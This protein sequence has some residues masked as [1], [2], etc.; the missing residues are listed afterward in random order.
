MK[1]VELAKKDVLL[2]LRDRKALM[3]LIAMPLILNAILGFALGGMFRGSEPALGGA[4]KI[5]VANEDQ[6]EL[7]RF[8]TDIFSSAEIRKLVTPQAATREE[9]IAAVDGGKASAAVIVPEGF[10]TAVGKGE[11]ASIEVY[12][13]PDSPL[14]GG[15]V[16]AIA[17]TLTDNMSAVQAAT[18]TGTRI[19]LESGVLKPQDAGAAAAELSAKLAQAEEA[20]G[21]Q[22]VEYRTVEPRQGVNSFQYYAAAMAAMFCLFTTTANGGKA[23]LEER[24]QGTLPRLLTTPTSR[25][26]IVGGKVIGTFAVAVLQMLAMIV[27]TSLVFRVSWGHSPLG[28]AVMVVSICVGASGVGVFIASISRT[29]QVADLISMIFIQLSA[30]V[31]GSMVPLSNLPDVAKKISLFTFNGQANDG[32]LKIMQ[33]APLSGI[34]SP[35]LILV[36]AGLVLSLIGSRRLAS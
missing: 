20:A 27:V 7:G 10:S 1:L 33:G 19:L 30:L 31:G 29:S 5:M 32:L 6:G 23:F 11:K 12:E 36:C 26:Q 34:W 21:T 25:W 35:A 16:H 4:F 28:L 3:I 22:R 2:V 24:E 14:K 13:H 9:A 18:A 17:T 15:I 8:V